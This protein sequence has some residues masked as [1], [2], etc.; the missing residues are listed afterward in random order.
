[1]LSAVICEFKT[2]ENNSKDQRSLLY[3]ILGCISSLF[4]FLVVATYFIVPEMRTLQN[5][6]VVFQSATLAIGLVSVS[7]LHLHTNLVDSPHACR[8]FG[9]FYYLTKYYYC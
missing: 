8:F 9:T 4:L 5:K 3:P 7:V 2:D 6:S 1:V